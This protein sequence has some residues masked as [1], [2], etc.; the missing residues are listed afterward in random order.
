MKIR[1]WTLTSIM[2]LLSCVSASSAQEATDRD[3]QS[4]GDWTVRCQGDT[5]KGNRRCVL[6]QS[7]HRNENDKKQQVMLT[8]VGYFSKDQRLGVLFTVPLGLFLPAGLMLKVDG[9]DD[10]KRL[11]Y[12]ICNRDGC[13]AGFPLNDRWLALFKRGLKGT[14]TLRT[15]RGKSVTIPLSLKGFTEGV[16]AIGVS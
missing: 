6:V 8:A 1:I 13:R 15:M 2:V 16:K 3:R 7:A 11:P 4:F 5:E 9:H 12:Q 10:I 14:V